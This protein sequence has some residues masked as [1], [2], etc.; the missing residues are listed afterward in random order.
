M[1]KF[2]KLGFLLLGFISSSAY[3]ETDCTIIVKDG[4]IG[5]AVPFILTPIN[6]AGA[7]S[8]KSDIKGKLFLSS[9]QQQDLHAVIYKLEF[10]SALANKLYVKKL[11]R[12]NNLLPEVAIDSY[13][14]YYLKDLC[15]TE[16]NE[17]TVPDLERGKMA[18]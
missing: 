13:S 14:G 5:E 4:V 8:I 18:Y 11:M 3:A 9:R 7:P 16:V 15:K 1:S 10:V 17:L 12:G 6:V 2:L